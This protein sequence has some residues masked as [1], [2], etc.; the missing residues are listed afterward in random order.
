LTQGRSGSSGPA[1]NERLFK[2]PEIKQLQERGAT[3]FEL[4]RKT[5]QRNDDAS[6]QNS[7][8]SNSQ[9]SKIP[10]FIAKIEK[11]VSPEQLLKLK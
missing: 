3:V 1:K 6:S 10:R 8:N 4:P 9:L 2:F 7:R 11:S 5:R